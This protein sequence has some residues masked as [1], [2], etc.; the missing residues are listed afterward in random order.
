MIILW[1]PERGKQNLFAAEDTALQI[2][3]DYTTWV[4]RMHCPLE[5]GVFYNLDSHHPL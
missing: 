5:E 1:Y 3:A 2:S 4:H